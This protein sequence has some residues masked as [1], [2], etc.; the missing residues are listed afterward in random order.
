MAIV[1]IDVITDINFVKN[2]VIHVDILNNTSFD[3]SCIKLVTSFDMLALDI[4]I[5]Q[6]VS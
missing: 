2:P 4:L 3:A 1:G 6:I 5:F